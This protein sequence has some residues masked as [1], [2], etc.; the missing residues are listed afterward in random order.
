MTDHMTLNMLLDGK[1]WNEPL[2]NGQIRSPLVDFNFEKVDVISNY[3]K[4]FVRELRYDCGELA[5]ATYLQA[6]T[7]NKD[8]VL[9][10]FVVSGNFHHKSVA[11]NTDRGNLTPKDLVGRRVG[12]RTYAQTTP[13]WVRGILQHE[14]GLD[15]ERVTWVTF[16]D[17]HLAEYTDPPNC[18]R[19]PAGKKLGQMLVDGEVDAA[20]M[21]VDMPNDPRLIRLIPDPD[22]AAKAWY[23]KYGITP[24]NHMFVVRAS[25]CKSRPDVVKE[26]YRMLVEARSGA[27]K[28]APGAPNLAPYGLEAVRESLKTIIEYAFEQHVIPR[29][30][31]VDELFDDTTRALG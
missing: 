12:V 27:A 19:A 24:I 15:L 16:G 31:S 1:P 28:P 29:K 5:I 9:L 11:Y 4:P 22:A 14:Y 25:L 6:K 7:Y 13:T 18:E 8:L 30:F 3:F 21:G 23:A 17:G 26:I 20:L 2:R 10:P